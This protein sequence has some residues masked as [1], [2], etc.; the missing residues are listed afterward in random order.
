VKPFDSRFAGTPE[1]AWASAGLSTLPLLDG[2][3]PLIQ[4][5]RPWV[6]AD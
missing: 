1:E 4:M 3:S 2:P 6:P 5:T